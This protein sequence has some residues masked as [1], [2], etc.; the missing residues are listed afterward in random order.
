MTRFGEPQPP[1]VTRVTQAYTGARKI[2]EPTFSPCGLMVCFTE[3]TRNDCVIHVCNVDGSDSRTVP[4]PTAPFYYSWSPDSKY[5]GWLA[6]AG[7]SITF[8]L[9]DASWPLMGCREVMRARPCFF[10]WSPNSRRL[11]VHAD[12]N[13]FLVLEAPFF[14]DGEIPAR[15]EIQ[16]RE[17]PLL[18]GS[19]MAPK[20]YPGSND[21]L[22]LVTHEVQDQEQS[23]VLYSTEEDQ[24]RHTFFITNEE[25]RVR[26][27][28]SPDGRKVA[29]SAW[30]QN[31]ATPF[32]YFNLQEDV[33]ARRPNVSAVVFSPFPSW[34]FSLSRSFAFARHLQLPEDAVFWE[35]IFWKTRIPR[36]TG[37]RSSSRST[38]SGAPTQRTSRF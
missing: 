36:W 1:L 12:L 20:W 11:A 7:N 25:N 16:R 35:R 5:I 26:F 32:F 19:L 18:P 6:N 34:F 30:D 28:I 21:L 23:L 22:L 13:R 29:V 4:V 10:A 27:I 38:F 9:V 37:W 8:Q 31:E 33:E 15:D 17:L 14:D 24:I 2:L 3:I